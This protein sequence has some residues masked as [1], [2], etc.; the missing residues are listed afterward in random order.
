MLNLESGFPYQTLRELNQRGHR[1]ETA[2]GP[3]GGYQAIA[4]DPDTGVYAGAS[5]SR[6]DGNAAGY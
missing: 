2:V 1:I 6:K 4:R 5:E 3:F